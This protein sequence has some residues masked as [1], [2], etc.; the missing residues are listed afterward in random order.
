MS[1]FDVRFA[2]NSLLS[3]FEKAVALF[4]MGTFAFAGSMYNTSDVGEVYIGF[5][6]V[7]YA[8]ITQRGILLV[9]YGSVLWFVRKAGRGAVLPIALTM[10]TL[11]ATAMV[12][13]GL[14]FTFSY[15][16][17]NYTFVVL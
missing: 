9:S 11:F 12:F 1:L 2:T 7:C 6:L 15:G 5:R 13:I 10:G 3:R 4:V 14:I 17:N 8:L 16:A